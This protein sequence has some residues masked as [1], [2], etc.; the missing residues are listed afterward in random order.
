MVRTEPSSLRIK[1]SLSEC[2]PAPQ[3]L[4]LPCFGGRRVLGFHC[5]R[6][7]P[8]GKAGRSSP[9][10]AHQRA[11]EFDQSAHLPGKPTDAALAR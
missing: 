1:I 5:G 11:A 8:P 2:F 10:P 4:L 9:R 7:G 3:W 6:T